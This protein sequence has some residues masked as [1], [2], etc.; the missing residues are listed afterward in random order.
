MIGRRGMAP[1]C[2]PADGPVAAH[3]A[4]HPRQQQP[5]AQ[6]RG[7]LL[8]AGAAACCCLVGVLWLAA[9]GRE[10]GAP[11]R[12]V[13][14][15]DDLRLPYGLQSD[16]QQPGALDDDPMED[17]W[18]KGGADVEAP[19]AP[20]ARSFSVPPTGVF[21]GHG[22]SVGGTPLTIGDN[23]YFVRTPARPAPSRLSIRLSICP[24]RCTRAQT[25]VHRRTNTRVRTP[26]PLSPTHALRVCRAER[27][28]PE[29]RPP[30]VRPG[31]DRHGRA[32]V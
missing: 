16:L 14:A 7:R 8:A 17:M 15:G 26:A 5:A 25:H 20:P 9:P 10:T 12:A 27:V 13:L 30:Q 11:R 2:A 19:P 31:D 23:T 4:W 24:A 1:G 29:A 22:H 18:I 21:T 32:D 3:R 28:R 6:S